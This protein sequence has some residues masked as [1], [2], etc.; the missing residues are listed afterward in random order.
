MA[1]ETIDVAKTK[2]IRIP[3]DLSIC[4]FDDNPLNVH[5]PVKLATVAQPLI[6]MGRLGLEILYQISHGKAKLPYKEVLSARLIKA[7]SM[8]KV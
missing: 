7:E 1:L 4:G 3:E 5:S 6:E 8:A 2:K